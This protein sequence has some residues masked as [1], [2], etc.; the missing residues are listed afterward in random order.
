M[1]PPRRSGPYGRDDP[2][3]AGSVGYG[4]YEGKSKGRNLAY[5]RRY[6]QRYGVGRGQQRP[7]PPPVPTP[8]PVD[9]DEVTAD[10]EEPMPEVPGQ[11][12][13]RPAG[14]PPVSRASA[15]TPSLTEARVAAVKAK[16]REAT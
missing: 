6:G 3:V 12:G 1:T 14:D 8:A 15:W 10:V 4:A 5:E 13:N 9:L 11:S 7:P 2:H 16:A